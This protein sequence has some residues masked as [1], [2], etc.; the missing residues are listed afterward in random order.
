M[1]RTQIKR[2]IVDIESPDEDIATYGAM[3]ILRLKEI[4]EAE[5]LDLLP[6][7]RRATT[8][9]SISVRFF[10]RK[11]LNEVK[12]GMRRHPRLVA[13][14]DKL[15][16]ETSKG[17]WSELLDGLLQTPTE[18][19]LV[20][21][22]L[23]KDVDDPKIL[24]AL[25]EYLGAERDEFVVAETIRVIG[26]LGHVAEIPLLEQYLKHRDSRIRS[27]AAEA[28][29]HIGGKAVVQSILP[30]LEDDDNRVKAT[31]AKLL[32]KQG[33]PHV[34][35]ALSEML[36]SVEV[37]MRESA[38]YALGYVPYQEAVDLLLEALVDVNSDVRVKAIESLSRLHARRAID[39]LHAIAVGG[40]P[41]VSQAAASALRI[42]RA[43]PLDYEYLDP[44]N[45]SRAATASGVRRRASTSGT[46]P[47]ASRSGAWAAA[48]PPGA[49]EQAPRPAGR[50][51]R[52]FARR[53]FGGGTRRA[54]RSQVEALKAE[55]D[56]ILL[57]IGKQV[58]ALYHEKTFERQWLAAQ[59]HEIKKIR[60]LIE[61]KESQREAIE[62][63]S[64]KITFIG[65][66]R[67]AVRFFTHEKQVG[68]RLDALNDRLAACYR[69]IGRRIAD[70]PAGRGDL[71]TL[72]LKGLPD[73]VQRLDRELRELEGTAGSPPTGPG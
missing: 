17:S 50:E 54:E 13:E 59:D 56:D 44:E 20:V 67:E 21:I 15:R 25:L 57:E 16:E 70:E 35:S 10:A 34:L 29:E 41:A 62:K 68:Q 55:R 30:L 71:D 49:A 72:Q 61:Q 24:P 51:R 19:K 28:L 36:H 46:R 12:L 45:A 38:I 33:E 39:Y 6:V 52:S 64:H 8:S 43:A 53:L 26:L 58:I 65:F 73:A 18:K 23:L 31:V 11:A 69:Q 32:S 27:N 60:Y 9:P 47:A 4:S 66:L 5:I 63:E 37:W 3:S 2:I 14:M 7:L 22:D 42:I 1:I 40:D 48:A